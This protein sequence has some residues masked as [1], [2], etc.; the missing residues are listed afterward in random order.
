MSISLRSVLGTVQASD[1]VLLRMEQL[2][3]WLQSGHHEV[4]L[5]P[6]VVVLVSAEL[7]YVHQTLLSISFR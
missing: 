5:F 7:R 6:L 4:S 3:L 2:M 1:S